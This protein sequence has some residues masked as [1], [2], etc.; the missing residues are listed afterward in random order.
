MSGGESSGKMEAH[1]RW[2][3]RADA[4]RKLLNII[5][6]IG[7]DYKVVLAIMSPMAG[8]AV[9]LYFFFNPLFLV[10]SIIGFEAFLIKMGWSGGPRERRR[11]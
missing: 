9:W 5:S 10:F 6:H 3:V 4:L 1:K 8:V 11:P 2:T 7:E